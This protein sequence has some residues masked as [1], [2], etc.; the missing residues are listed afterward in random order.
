VGEIAQ[1]S[2]KTVNLPPLFGL[3]GTLG[4]ER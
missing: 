4:A 3:R 1:I 2:P